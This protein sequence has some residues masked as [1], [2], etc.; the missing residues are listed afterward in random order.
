MDINTI[1]PSTILVRAIKYGKNDTVMVNELKKRGMMIP[2]LADEANNILDGN[3]RYFAALHL[4][5]KDVP[6]VY[7]I[8]EVYQAY[9]SI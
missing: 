1:K 7:S 5:M 2:I 8:E 3:R 4:G 9:Q 6:V